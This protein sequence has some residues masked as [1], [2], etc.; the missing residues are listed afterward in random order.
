MFCPDCDISFIVIHRPASRDNTLVMN[1][2]RRLAVDS[3][4]LLDDSAKS[5]EAKERV[6]QGKTSR[7]EFTRTMIE[8]RR[9]GND[10][11]EPRKPPNAAGAR[12]PIK[13]SASASTGLLVSA[14]PSSPT[15]TEV[16]E[17]PNNAAAVAG[18]GGKTGAKTGSGGGGRGRQGAIRPK[19]QPNSSASTLR[20]LG[21]RFVRATEHAPDC[22]TGDGSSDGGLP[23]ATSLVL[24]T[25]RSEGGGARR[26]SPSRRGFGSPRR[27]DAGSLSGG[28]RPWSVSG[29]A[30]RSILRLLSGP[31]SPER[32]TTAHSPGG[33]PVRGDGS[34]VDG[35]GTSPDHRQ[36]LVEHDSSGGRRG[37]T[38]RGSAASAVRGS[39]RPMTM[40]GGGGG[41][42]GG[43]GGGGL[44]P[45]LTASEIDNMSSVSNTSTVLTDLSVRLEKIEDML[46]RLLEVHQ[47]PRRAE[48]PSRSSHFG[49]QSSQDSEG[50]GGSSSGSKRP[51]EVGWADHTS[52][53]GRSWSATS[54]VNRTEQPDLS[55][56][57]VAGVVRSTT[58]ELYEVRAHLRYLQVQ[59]QA[60]TAAPSGAVAAPPPRGMLP[61][62]TTSAP[63]SPPPLP[64]V[65]RRNDGTGRLPNMAPASELPTFKDDHDEDGL[66]QP[67][68]ILEE[69]PTAEY[70]DGQE[71]VG[72]PLEEGEET[73]FY[74]PLAACS[75]S[76]S[77]LADDGDG[78]GAYWKET[79]DTDQMEESE[80]ESRP[81]DKTATRS[82]SGRNPRGHSRDMD[83]AQNIAEFAERKSQEET[84]DGQ[85][86]MELEVKGEEPEG[87]VAAVREHRDL[88]AAVGGIGSGGAGR[89]LRR[90]GSFRL[91]TIDEAPT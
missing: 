60:R 4:M 90:P 65:E 36:G 70:G 79:K 52:R 85:N 40:V 77:P 58:E 89:V 82:G 68:N 57:R 48:A 13:S 8:L 76:T 73:M 28:Q 35:G 26:R 80:H 7:P 32:P 6:R 75:L 66:R 17:M 20:K 25:T 38:A 2:H 23:D 86:R 42:S 72:D 83:K 46:S 91:S 59:E 62:P 63:R 87:A 64:T 37:G 21:G 24:D 39:I 19:R 69:K 88:S 54:N 56:G 47:K 45:P 22:D 29:S 14:E 74:S 61:S 3:E 41:G 78:D 16:W 49:S 30:G 18:D 50:G 1:L 12:P 31:S 55:A 71:A 11:L 10:V 67:S 34:V 81:S 43:S 33:T 5:L 44:P 9:N 51:N 53:G 27:R 84:G 15:I